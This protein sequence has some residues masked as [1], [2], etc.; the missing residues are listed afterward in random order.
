MLCKHFSFASQSVKQAMLC[1][2]LPSYMLSCGDFHEVLP[3]QWL[4]FGGRKHGGWEERSG[5]EIACLTEL[6]S[7]DGR[8]VPTSLSFMPA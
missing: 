6:T 3:V 7:V 2:S 5:T 1:E 8:M 4:W